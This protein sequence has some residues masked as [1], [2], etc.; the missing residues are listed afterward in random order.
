MCFCF[1]PDL[2][3]WKKVEATE[4]FSKIKAELSEKLCMCVCVC[5]CILEQ[6]E[7]VEKEVKGRGRRKRKGEQGLRER[8]GWQEEVDQLKEG[9]QMT[10]RWVLGGAGCERK[11][12][13]GGG[14]GGWSTAAVPC[15]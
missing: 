8:P 13:P 9:K 1:W 15:C 6:D 5:L 7:G 4:L 10:G 14:G 11:A 12:R 3:S 2:S